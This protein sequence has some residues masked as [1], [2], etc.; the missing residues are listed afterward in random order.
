[1]RLQ[2]ALNYLNHLIDQDAEFPDAFDRVCW[3]FRLT[4]EEWNELK[5]MYDAQEY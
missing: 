4:S 1:M 3:K 5:Q 2:D